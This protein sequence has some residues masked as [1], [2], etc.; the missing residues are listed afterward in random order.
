MKLYLQFTPYF[1]VAWC[2]V[3]YRIRLYGVLL[4]QAR[5]ILPLIY[6]TLPSFPGGK[7]AGAWSWPLTPSSAEVEEYV[8][9]YLH[10]PNTPSWRGAQLKHRDNFT[11]TLPSITAAV[12]TFS[13]LTF[14]IARSHSLQIQLLL[15]CLDMFIYSSIISTAGNFTTTLRVLR[16][17]M[18]E[19]SA[20]YGG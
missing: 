15:A 1:F 19:T 9:L 17:R 20:K 16:L 7:A 6:L 2:L 14:P 8:E 12:L 11:F 13:W 3:K 5:A 10:S 18:E 4:S